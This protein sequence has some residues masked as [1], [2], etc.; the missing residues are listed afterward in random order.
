MRGNPRWY[1]TIEL[2]PGEVTPGLVDLRAVAP[3]VLP[4]RIEGRALDVGTY[5]GFWA[6]EM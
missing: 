5:D 2:A 4:A 6:F 1:H 3:R